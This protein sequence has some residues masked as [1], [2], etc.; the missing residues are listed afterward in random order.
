MT[1][2]I[3]LVQE[4]YTELSATGNIFKQKQVP[5]QVTLHGMLIYVDNLLQTHRPF[6]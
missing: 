6:P 4:S 2:L 1:D 5:T 3:Y